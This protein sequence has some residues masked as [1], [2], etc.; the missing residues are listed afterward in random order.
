MVVAVDAA[1]LEELRQRQQQQIERHVRAVGDQVA[2]AMRRAM[3]E[4]IAATAGKSALTEA[5]AD[6]LSKL[7]SELR[8][9]INALTPHRA[10]LH[11]ELAASLD[12][13]LARQMLLHGA[14]EL[15]DVHGLVGTVVGRLRQLC[16]PAQ[17]AEVE[18]MRTAALAEPNPACVLAS[19]LM[20]ADGILTAIEDLNVQV[21]ERLEAA[22]RSQGGGAMCAFNPL[23]A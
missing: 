23:E 18:E 8:D 14:A 19:L 10:D 21:K 20:R 7:L 13:D 4:Q 9:R 17:D 3:H 15:S 2:L 1:E 6:W 12:V 16:A 11:A 22:T 5:D